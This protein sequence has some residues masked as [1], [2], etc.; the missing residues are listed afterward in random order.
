MEEQSRVDPIGLFP[1]EMQEGA[2]QSTHLGYKVRRVE[3]CGNVFVLE[4]IRPHMKYVIGQVLEP[5]RNT[6]NEPDAWAALHVGVALTS[7]NGD[8]AF[9]PQTTDNPAD[10]VRARLYWLTGPSGQWQ[11]VIDYLF[12]QYIEMENEVAAEIVELHRLSERSR[13]TS[14]PSLDSSTAPGH[15]SGETAGDTQPTEPSS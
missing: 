14:L 12:G 10:F 7:Y 9:C 2:R 1:A 3:F 6:I 13:A 8:T 15:S 5:F 11:P 4:T